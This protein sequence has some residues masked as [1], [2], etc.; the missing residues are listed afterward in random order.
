MPS[1]FFSDEPITGDTAT[2]AGP[3]AHHLLHVMRTAVGDRV[4]LFDGSGVEFA[5][6][7]VRLGRGDATLA[8]LASEPVDRELPF[9]LTL[10]VAMPKGDR[11]KVLVEKLTELGVTRLRPVVTARTVV[12]L[13]PA[14]LEKLRRL[15]IESSKQ[16]GRNRLMA[17]DEPLPFDR[18]VAEAEADERFFAHPGGA[19]ALSPGATEDVAIAIGPE[20]GFTDEEATF[21]EEAGWTA[22]SLGSR[23]L[24]IETAAIAAAAVRASAAP[25]C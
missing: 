20:G 22:A 3:E 11:Q 14:A 5:A 24:R 9:T 17:I 2:L 15:V 19:A 10:G 1:R 13:K 25:G 23:I 4:T 21:G 6:E 18:F 8:V 16:C 12:E 7:V